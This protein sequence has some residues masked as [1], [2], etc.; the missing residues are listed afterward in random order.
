MSRRDAFTRKIL[1][2]YITNFEQG[3]VNS[4]EGVFMKFLIYDES[5]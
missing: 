4:D 1:E 2:I 3:K 5:E